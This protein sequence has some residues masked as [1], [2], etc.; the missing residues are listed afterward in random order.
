MVSASGRIYTANGGG[1]LK[2]YLRNQRRREKRENGRE[3]REKKRVGGK[4]FREGPLKEK[5]R[6]G[7]E[8]E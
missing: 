5:G 7:E 4:A 1:N 8:S 3:E 6:R 2:I